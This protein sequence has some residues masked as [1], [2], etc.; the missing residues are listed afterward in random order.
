MNSFNWEKNLH[1]LT[2]YGSFRDFVWN[3]Y[4]VAQMK[5]DLATAREDFIREVS[6]IKTLQSWQPDE[7]EEFCDKNDAVEILGNQSTE[8]IDVESTQINTAIYRSL[9]EFY[10]THK[11][12]FDQ[13]PGEKII[14]IISWQPAK[15]WRK[16]N[17][18]F[19][20]YRSLTNFIR[21]HCQA[22]DVIFAHHY[23]NSEEPYV[24]A[25]QAKK[26]YKNFAPGIERY[27]KNNSGTTATS[28][29]DKVNSYIQNL[30]DKI[31]NTSEEKLLTSPKA[32]LGIILHEINPP[33]LDNA[34]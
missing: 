1:E 4:T 24:D 25:D 10:D 19:S 17:I 22:R 11:E 18:D 16:R 5:D 30:M 27:I 29:V 28:T 26:I 15:I 34:G 13:H 21:A 3:N 20:N 6:T 33:G 32:D 14:D 31:Y 12:L 9:E 2:R 23:G 7:I 8:W